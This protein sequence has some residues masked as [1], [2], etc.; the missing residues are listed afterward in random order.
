MKIKKKVLQEYLDKFKMTA[1][2][3]AQEI[4]VETAEVEK[5]L[6]DNAVEEKTARLFINY[7]GAE[8]ARH[9][10]DWEAMNKKDPFAD[11]V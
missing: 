6:N 9:F 2:A 8:E 10:I 5:M 11:E 7:F 4:G 3:F 1:A